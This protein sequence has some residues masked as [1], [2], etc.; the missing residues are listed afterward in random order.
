MQR[1]I[2]GGC[3]NTYFLVFNLYDHLHMIF[4]EASAH[5]VPNTCP[6]FPVESIHCLWVLV[7][8]AYIK[9]SK[10]VNSCQKPSTAVENHRQ[11]SKTIDSHRKPS[12]DYIILATHYV[13]PSKTIDPLH[14]QCNSGPFHIYSR[15]L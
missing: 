11:P 9:P 6:A 5:F 1:T 2:A 13:K 3:A 12:T 4:E 15:V 14:T 10:T 8:P 7:W